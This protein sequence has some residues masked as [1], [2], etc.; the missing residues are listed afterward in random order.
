MGEFCRNLH[1]LK[2]LIAMDNFSLEEKTFLLVS[3]SG[4]FMSLIGLIGNI[5]L[6]LSII[7]LIIPGINIALDCVCITYFTK[8][9]KWRI[10][11][12]VVILYAIFI[13]FPFLWFSTGGATGSTMPFVVLIGIFVVVAFK[14][15][16][17]LTILMITIAMF[18]T[19]SMLEIRYPRIYVPYP[20]REAHM[21]DLTIGMFLSY[22]VSVY[23]AYQVL[24]SY[25]KSK[26]ETEA[27]VQRLEYSSITDGLT[28]IYNRRYLTMCINEE[29]RKSYD[30]GSDLALC[31]MDIDHFKAINDTYG[32]VYG[33]EVLVRLSECA[34]ELM[35]D[36]E[37]FGRY[38][39]EEFVIIFKNSGLVPAIRKM[40]EIMN[41]IRSLKWRGDLHVT[42]SAGLSV[43]HK[44]LNFSKFLENADKNLY[45]A[46]ENGRD[47]CVHP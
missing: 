29:M 36:N 26:R 43:Y 4:I 17:R 20:S 33:D 30:D 25:I 37:V 3:V 22:T 34:R 44:G 19:F 47:R 35:S 46:K 21:I 28:G 45:V 31:I 2:N 13:L 39:G 27:L 23:L 38:G 14:G 7:T 10:P 1:A 15:R 40:D 42:I 8:T 6:G 41:R 32:H 5:T 9:R 18:M 16:F 24:G 12:V 11:S